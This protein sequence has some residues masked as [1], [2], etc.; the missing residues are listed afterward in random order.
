MVVAAGGIF[1]CIF[2][3]FIGYM[4]EIEELENP[5]NKYASQVIS[6]DGKLIGTWS[7]S[8]ANRIF[9]GYNDVASSVIQALVATE[10]ERFYEHSGI[11]IKAL[12]RAIVKRGI[13]MQKSAGG[14]STI[15]QQLAK[16]LYSEKAENIKERLLQKPIEW[17]IALKLE[18]YY[19]KEEILTMYLN[20]FDFL[21]NAVGI[22]TAAKTYFGKDPKDLTVTESATLIGMCKNP[23]YFNPVRNPERCVQRRNVVLAQMEKAGYITSDEADQLNCKI[24]G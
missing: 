15:T 24:Y 22:K 11:D 4:P 8:R 2:N 13:F 16:Q 14:G 21:H 18:R 19:T 9:V 17:V 10:D 3:G 20:H 23:S 12:F 6:A 7:Y 5:V 1:Y